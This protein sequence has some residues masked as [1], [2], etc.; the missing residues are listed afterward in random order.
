MVASQF[1]NGI[2]RSRIGFPC[3]SGSD[4]QLG[5]VGE[6]SGLKLSEKPKNTPKLIKI[7]IPKPI[8]PLRDGVI[9]E[10]ARAPP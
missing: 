2:H 10:P 7:T 5:K 6:P 4:T 1:E 3:R 9:E 8:I